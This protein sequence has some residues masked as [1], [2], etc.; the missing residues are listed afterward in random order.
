MGEA[1]KGFR[2]HSALTQKLRRVAP[3]TLS[4]RSW[5]TWSLVYYH[6]HNRSS[7]R[8]DRQEKSAKSA[9]GEESREREKQEPRS[10]MVVFGRQ[11]FSVVFF[12]YEK[13]VTNGQK[14]T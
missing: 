3:R 7:N 4:C 9:T 12:F 1:I 6:M 10:V 8:R 11:V 2:I 5:G 13:F 14:D